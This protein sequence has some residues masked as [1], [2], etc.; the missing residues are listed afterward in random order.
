MPVFG[1]IQYAIRQYPGVIQRGAQFV[2]HGAEVF[3]DDHAAR[4]HT[5]ECQDRQQI[6]QGIADEC[7]IGCAAASGDPEQTHQADDMINT[8]RT[9]GTHIRA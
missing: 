2:G 8:Q 5:L 4:T 3:T 9:T 1:K 7:A 6:M